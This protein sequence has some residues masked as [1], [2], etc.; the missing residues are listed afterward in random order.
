MGVQ[1]IWAPAFVL[2]TDHNTIVLVWWHGFPIL[3]NNKSKYCLS[4]LALYIYVVPCG[5]LSNEWLK[6]GEMVW[7]NPSCNSIKCNLPRILCINYEH[8]GKLKIAS[9]SF[10]VDG[11]EW[12]KV[13]VFCSQVHTF[14][15]RSIHL[16]WKSWSQLRRRSFSLLLYSIIQTTQLPLDKSLE[17]AL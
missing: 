16:E 8:N 17:L 11:K 2:P 7:H 12:N 6:T 4:I 14:N 9:H 15:Q 1:I 13:S 5:W 3:I 10:W